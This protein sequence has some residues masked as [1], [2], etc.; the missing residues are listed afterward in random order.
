[1][2]SSPLCVFSVSLFSLLTVAQLKTELLGSKFNSI[3]EETTVSV[4]NPT[5]DRCRHSHSFLSFV[6]TAPRLPTMLWHGCT[7]ANPKALSYRE[8]LCVHVQ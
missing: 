7:H 4:L 2:L 5:S 8:Y 1:M 6:S 3:L